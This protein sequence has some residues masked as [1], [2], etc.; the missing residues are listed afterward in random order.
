[1]NFP[2]LSNLATR[3][4]RVPVG[5][6]DVAGSVPGHIGGLVE[7]VAGDT[8]ARRSG[9]AAE[10]AAA[11]EFAYRLEPA[12]QGQEDLAGVVELDDHPRGAVHD[13]DVVLGIDPDALRKQEGVGALVFAGADLAQELSGA[14][15]FEEARAAADVDARCANRW[16]SGRRPG[17]RPTGCPWRWWPRRPL[18]RNGCRPA[19]SE[20][21]RRNRTRFLSAGRQRA[22]EERA[23]EQQRG[24]E[25]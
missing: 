25:A 9:R 6:E 24:C 16:R 18:H 20:N 21:H 19:A 12:A 7:I 2:F 22:G 17:S 11:A 3:A 15:E 4:L 8:R 5:D 1:M 10:H 23:G 13:P 14:V